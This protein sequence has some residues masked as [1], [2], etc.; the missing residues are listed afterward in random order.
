VD[1]RIPSTT[2]AATDFPFTACTAIPCGRRTRCFAGLD[3]LVFDIQDAG[4]RFYTYITTMGCAMEAAA[5][6]HLAFTFS[7]VPILLEA[8]SSKDPCW[9][10]N[11]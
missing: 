11:A 10:R 7:I 1:E 2:D 9:T 5:S 8:R 3:A 4:V 6:H